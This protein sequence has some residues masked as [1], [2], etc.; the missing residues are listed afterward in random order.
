MN[1]KP[2]RVI[3]PHNI[4]WASRFISE[5]AAWGR[6]ISSKG[7]KL[8]TPTVRAT[9]LRQGWRVKELEI[10]SADVLRGL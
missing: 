4:A 2:Y 9:L 1:D 8:D 7:Y 6:L 5:E 3:S 10:T